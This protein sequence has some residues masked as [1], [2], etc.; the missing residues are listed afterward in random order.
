[1]VTKIEAFKEGPIR[2]LEGSIDQGTRRCLI[3]AIA[4]DLELVGK[5]KAGMLIREMKKVLRREKSICERLFYYSYY[6]Y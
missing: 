1:M 2:I 4:I 3:T 6:N 5:Y